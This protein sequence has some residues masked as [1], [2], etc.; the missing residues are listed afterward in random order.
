MVESDN[1]EEGWAEADEYHDASE[2]PSVEVESDDE[3]DKY[4]D[5]SEPPTSIEP[6]TLILEISRCSSTPP[7]GPSIG[8]G[9]PIQSKPCGMSIATESSDIVF[10]DGS[11]AVESLTATDTVKGIFTKPLEVDMRLNM[12]MRMCLRSTLMDVVW[13]VLLGILFAIA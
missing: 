9:T 13:W 6:S 8:I 3:V 11:S 7:P 10:L 2:G 12:H 1:E 5:T 4:H